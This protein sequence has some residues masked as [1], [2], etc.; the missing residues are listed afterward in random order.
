MVILL[1][2][3]SVEWLHQTFCVGK[4]LSPEMTKFIKKQTEINIKGSLEDDTGTV[5]V[6]NN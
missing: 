5:L 4:S 1:L 2:S 6:S 3:E